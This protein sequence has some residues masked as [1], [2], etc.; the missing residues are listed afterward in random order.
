MARFPYG[1]FSK[2]RHLALGFRR[3]RN[4]ATL[5]TEERQIDDES[6]SHQYN[7]VGNLNPQKGRPDR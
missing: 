1:V 4:Q 5:Q 2:I 3:H 7:A 6:L